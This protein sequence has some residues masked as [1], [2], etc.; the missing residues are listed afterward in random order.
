MFEPIYMLAGLGVGVLVGL[1]GIGG[2][3]LMTPL[4]VLGFGQPPLTAV[5]TDLILAAVTK[6]VATT[7]HGLR[8]QVDWTVLGRLSLGSLPTALATVIWLGQ[9]QR[10]RATVD[11]LIL[12]A[13]GCVLVGTCIV[14]LLL[15]PLRRY[16]LQLTRSA[17]S[18]F[19]RLQPGLTVLTG[20]V[21]GLAVTLTSVGAGALGTVAL[22]YLYPL[23]LSPLR[24]VATDLAHALPL[25]L[26]AGLGHAALG[27]VDG[28]LLVNLLCGSVPGV[29]IGTRAAAYVPSWAL[30][31]L[32]GIMLG[33]TGLRLLLH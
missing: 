10:P 2:G 17:L 16:G 32:I 18:R 33:I 26:I 7:L 30:R 1:T 4:L 8:G 9:T 23:R 22:L 12:E 13:L 14:M 15:G 27:H 28:L 19:Q 3:S 21:L 31:T 6:G 24:L 25:T 20:V 29:L 5:G 11:A